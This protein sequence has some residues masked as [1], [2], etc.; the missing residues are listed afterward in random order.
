MTET[1]LLDEHTKMHETHKL[2]QS[3]QHKQKIVEKASHYI[4]T[5]EKKLDN[6]ESKV[7]KKLHD[8]HLNDKNWVYLKPPRFVG[9]SDFYAAYQEKHL[10]TN[11][12]HYKYPHLN[13]SFERVLD[14][15]I[16]F[17]IYWTL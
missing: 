8:A 4:T 6:P 17:K 1:L 12:L 15:R 16:F 5:M 14:G 11:L 3:I 9:R 10:V 7:R 13:F 2:K